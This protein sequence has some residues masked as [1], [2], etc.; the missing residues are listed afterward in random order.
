MLFFALFFVSLVFL[1]SFT[2]VFLAMIVTGILPTRMVAL[3]F[4]WGTLGHF[5]QYLCN[6]A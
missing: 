6:Y 4:R 5:C 3:A 2:L 1:A